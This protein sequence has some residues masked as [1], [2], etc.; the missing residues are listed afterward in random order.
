[1]GEQTQNNFEENKSENADVNDFNKSIFEKEKD[2]SKKPKKDVDKFEDIE[3][4]S[5]KQQL[6]VDDTKKLNKIFSKKEFFD[7]IGYGF[8]P[9]Q[10]L[11]VF[12]FLIGTPVFLV[13]ILNALKDVLTVFFSSFL[14]DYSD[15]TKLGKKFMSNAGLLFGFSFLLIALAIRIKSILLFSFAFILGSLGVAIYGELYN[16]LINEKL[17]YDRRNSFLKNIAHNGLFI[18]AISFLIS[19]IILQYFG[20]EDIIYKINIFGFVC[21]CPINGYLIIYEIGAICF[22]LSSFFISKL[23]EF[24]KVGTNSIFSFVHVYLHQISVQTRIFFH[25]KKLRLMLISVM[26]IGVIQTLGNSYYGYYIYSNFNN[27]AFGGFLNL[28][29]IFVVSIFLSFF[30]PYIINYL[31]KH[32]G[33][34][35]MFIFGS[36]LLA[37]LPLTL[38]YNL[39]F[40]TVLVANSLT[41][42][43]S[44]II[45]VSHGLISNKLL[46]NTEKKFY[47]Q[48]LSVMMVWP[49][50]ILVPIGAFLTQ[51]YGFL[52]LFKILIIALVV[53]ILPINIR[54]LLMTEK[55]KL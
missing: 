16:R 55:Q 7:R 28:A 20:L 13:G 27:Y 38:A 44:S 5:S 24:S 45:G 14:K 43:G 52:F 11:L 40:L 4:Y 23:P 1:M 17:S 39:H 48:S 54:L 31:K 36:L 12:F 2:L 19:G 22:I 33:L 42:L 6:V 41:L 25:N 34:T 47:F 46:N 35:P 49:Y 18:T 53:I 8:V 9:N 29:I 30:A 26:L 50:L 10:F 51:I 15:K 3:N 37:L 32:I 21:N